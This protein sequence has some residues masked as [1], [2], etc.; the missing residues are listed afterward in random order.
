MY[1]NIEEIL[2]LK[3]NLSDMYLSLKRNLD[4]ISSEISMINNNLQSVSLAKRNADILDKVASL[5]N[6]VQVNLSGLLDFMGEQV[7]KYIV[8]TEEANSALQ[9]LINLIGETF[10]RNG[11]ILSANNANIGA[12]AG[13]AILGATTINSY[14]HTNYMAPNQAQ[15]NTST[16]NATVTETIKSNKQSSQAHG[17]TSQKTIT[18]KTNASN[19]QLTATPM[20]STTQQA[21]NTA[22]TGAHLTASGGVFNG[23]SGKETYYNMKM[24]QVVKNMRDLGYSETEYPYWVREDGVKMLGDYVMAAAD[25]NTRPKGTILNTSLGQAIVCDTGQFTLTNPTQVDIAVGWGKNPDKS[26]WGQRP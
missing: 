12:L 5:S 14:K 9:A 20:S 19:D 22:A 11:N 16:V 4:G 7:N 25:F 6:S 15:S 24:G 21:T 10:D 3:T 2:K 17:E 18:T 8:T 23:P 26:T 1:I 13:S